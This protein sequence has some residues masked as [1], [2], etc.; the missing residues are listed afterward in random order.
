M[1]APFVAL[2]L[3]NPVAPA[4]APPTGVVRVWLGSASPLVRG[5]AVRVYVEAREDGNLVVLRR[6]TDGRIEVL[7]PRNPD[8][9]PFVRAGTYEIR[10]TDERGAWVLAEPDGTGMVLAALS[11]D[12][13][14]FDEFVRAAAWDPNALVPTWSGADAAGSMSDIV[15]RMLG[16]GYFNYDLVAY[17]VAPPVYAQQDLTPQQTTPAYDAY[18]TCLNCTF[19]GEQ[20]II[21]EPLLVHRRFRRQRETE[22]RH[23]TS[24]IALAGG[25]RPASI[26]QRLSQGSR[27][28]APRHAPV[29]TPIEPRARERPN[30]LPTQAMGPRTHVRFTRLSAP[31]PERP[32]AAVAPRA[33]A[34][35]VLVARAGLAFARRDSPG[36]APVRSDF[37]IREG[38][39]E[40]EIPAVSQ[41]PERSRAVAVARTGEG[42]AQGATQ[43]IAIPREAW[44]Y[45]R[46]ATLR[47]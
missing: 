39:R 3:Q 31:T 37:A 40:R 8:T 41:A 28:A 45:S 26:P 24:A 13:L 21:Y 9:D 35:A 27:F 7:F 47:R 1:I 14:K 25:P 46:R 29:A 19:I 12:P 17:T 4:A 5:A 32:L 2:L 18:P 38:E 11:P 36:R 23:P 30:A 16:D 42:V 10:G 34:A 43:G 20:L 33:G 6:R 22:P 44:G 15:Q